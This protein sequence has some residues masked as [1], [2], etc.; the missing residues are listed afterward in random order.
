MLNGQLKNTIDVQKLN[1]SLLAQSVSFLCGKHHVSVL[2]DPSDIRKPES[3]CLEHLGWVKDLNGKWVRG[4]RTFNS[5]CLDL[6][7]KQ[8]RLLA[9]TPYS[10]KDPD[11]VSKTLLEKY[12]K[13]RLE[14][15]NECQRIGKALAQN[16]HYNLSIITRTQ[17]QD[18]HDQFKSVCPTIVLTHIL[19]REFVDFDLMDWLTNE[20]E[21]KFI[22]RLKANVTSNEHTI[23]AHTG[24]EIPLKLIAK[25]DWAYTHTIHFKS[26]QFKGKPYANAKA[27]IEWDTLQKGDNTYSVIRIRA[28]DQNGKRIFKDPMLLITNYVVSKSEIA[29]YVWH[30]YLQR[31]KI[32]SVFKFCKQALGWEHFRVRDYE[33][34]KNIISLTY[35]VAA[36]FYEI[37]HE[38]T[39]D[40]TVQ[41][42]CLLGGAKGKVSRNYFLAGIAQLL[43][44]H[45]VQQFIKE[46]NISEEQIQKALRLFIPLE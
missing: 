16:S 23:E 25:Q 30:Q 41:W 5:V 28:Y 20:L 13:G 32:E 29:H 4:Y 15:P 35:F 40:H 42:I 38:L 8:V 45:K 2:H 21:D 3:K 34:I 43:T 36:Y 46:Q 37:E 27:I 6:S 11:Y 14:D 31:S 1:V 7:S 33:S 22:I 17:I 39:K 12:Q 24:R 18:I 9:C 44:T 19:D 26:I 10:S